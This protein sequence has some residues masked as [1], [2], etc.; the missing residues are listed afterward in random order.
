MGGTGGLGGLG[1]MSPPG[2]VPTIPTLDLLVWLD[3]SRVD[4]AD[5]DSISPWI[6]YGSIA[7]NATAAGA[8]RPTLQTNEENGRSTL[9][10]DGVDD[11]MNLSYSTDT[12]DFSVYA[13]VKATNFD[14]W[15][16]IVA[17]TA[18]TNDRNFYF[19]ARL[20]SGLITIGF[21][22]AAGVYEELSTAAAITAGDISLVGGTFESAADEFTVE[23]GGTITTGTET[24]EVEQNGHGSNIEVGHEFNAEEWVGD[25]FEILV[26]NRAI[27]VNER[28][29]VRNYLN[30]KWAVY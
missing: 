16:C 9:R 24:A 14:D 15:H 27:T 1:G 29:V 3:A 19:I 13:V 7:A 20:T 5:T 21:T 18:D 4:G 23:Q 11:E 22:S 17:K 25:L 10:F 30:A 12:G 28:T 6:N 8:A 26:Y 2:G